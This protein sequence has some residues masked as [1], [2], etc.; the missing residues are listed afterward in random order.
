MCLNNKSEKYCVHG[1]KCHFRHVEA[2]GKPNEKSKKGG[3]N[4]SVAIVKEFFQ[5]CCESQDSDPRKSIP[6]EPRM[7]GT[8]HAV[9][10]SKGTWHQIKIRERKGPSRGI[11]QKSAPHE[12]CLCAPKFEERS[13]EETLHQERC[14]RKSAWDLAKNNE[15]L[16]NA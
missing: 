1:D 10:F 9:K 7:L 11:I 14:A 4:G 13:H 6:R 5:V 2:E 8:E 16:K 3:A 12:R 15:M